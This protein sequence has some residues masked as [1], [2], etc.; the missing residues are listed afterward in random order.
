[1]SRIPLKLHLIFLSSLTVLLF[2]KT[3]FPERRN[4]EPCFSYNIFPFYISNIGIAAVLTA[5]AVVSQYKILIFPYRN[6]FG[7]QSCIFNGSC[8]YFFIKQFSIYI[9]CSILY[10]YLI[11]RHPNDTLYII[12]RLFIS[13]WK[14]YNNI[15]CFWFL[16]FI[17]KT[18][19]QNLF[20]VLYRRV[21]GLSYHSGPKSD[22]IY[23]YK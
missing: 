12:M 19:N 23:K 6:L 17:N 16:Q 15:I 10:L 21:H 18:I 4:P 13:I 11:S 3:D 2:D 5:V 9:D 8:I 20:S 14:K 1:M 22:K 7:C